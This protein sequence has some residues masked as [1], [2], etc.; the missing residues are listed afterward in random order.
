MINYANNFDGFSIFFWVRVEFFLGWK[1]SEIG[2]EMASESTGYFK[3][4]TI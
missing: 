2:S 3:N 4:P 1:I